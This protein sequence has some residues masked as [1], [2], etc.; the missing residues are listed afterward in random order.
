MPRFFFDF[1]QAGE[2]TADSTGTEL[3]NTEQAYLEAF[4]AAQEMWS[5]LL[6]QRRDPR[7]C[8]FEVRSEAGDILF[9]F[10]LQEVV[11]SCLDRREATLR[12]TFQQLTTTYNYARR[13]R[14]ELSREMKITQQVLE[15]SRT[16]LR[17]PAEP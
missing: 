6:K 13:I 10:P 1:R 4:K 8:F 3:A 2:F 7:R 11:D 17:P 12:H 16:L 14:D 5:E 9:I 15:D